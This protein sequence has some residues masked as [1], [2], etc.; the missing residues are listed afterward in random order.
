MKVAYYGL[1]SEIPEEGVEISGESMV[2]PFSA[3][4]PPYHRVESDGSVTFLDW[5]AIFDVVD[6]A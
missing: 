5:V 3:A 1:I 4:E 6:E 2:M